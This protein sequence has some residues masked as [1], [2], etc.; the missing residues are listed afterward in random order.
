[1]SIITV[2]S[3]ADKGDG[4]LR[5]AIALA[6][7]EDNILFSSRLRGKTIKLKS[8]QL[9]LNKNLTID[10]SNAPE[11]VISGNN[12]SR[13][14]YLDREKRATIKNL[15]IADGK[16][17]G[18]GGGIDARHESVLLLDNVKVNNNKSELGGGIRV[19]HLAKATILNSS[20]Y[21]NDGTLSKKFADQSGGAITHSESR[22]QIFVKNTTFKKNKGFN[23]GAIFSF[24][25]VTLKVEDS[26]FIQ[27]S[28]LNRAG[29]G[30]IFTDGVS[31]R[32]YNSGFADDG[33]II[34]RTSRFE[35]NKAQGDGGALYLWGYRRDKAIL[36]DSIFINNTSTP[37]SNGKSKGGA[38]WVKMEL[39]MHNVT[40]ANNTA[41]Q[42]GGAVWLESLLPAKIVNSTFSGNRAVR[43]AG[44]A[45]FINSRTAPVNLTN[46]TIAY[47]KAGRA[48]GALWLASNHNVRLSNSIVAFNT[49]ER[50]RRQDQ[51]GYQ[52]RDGGG[53]LEYPLSPRAN[54]VFDNS[55][56]ANP[57]L[58][59]LKI[60]NGSLVHALK[61][62]SPAIN[63]GSN[64][65][66]PTADQRGALRDNQIDIGAFEVSNVST[67]VTIAPNPNNAAA[68][69]ETETNPV[70]AYFA[71]DESRGRRAKD[72]SDRYR[73]PATLSGGAT[74]APGKEQGG[75]IFNGEGAVKVSKNRA[76]DGKHD[77]R[78]VSLWFKPETTSPGKRQVLYEEGG[79]SRGLNIY[80]DADQLYVGGWNT[81]Q[82]ES[83]WTGTWLKADNI[84][85]DE[86][87]QVDLVLDGVSQLQDNALKGYL[88]GQLFD[89]GLGSQIWGHTDGIG[90]GN[91]NR[92]TRFHDGV[93]SSNKGFTGTIDEV[94]IANSV[95]GSDEL[96]TFL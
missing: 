63:A 84:L 6:K 87:H 43:D 52:P 93:T 60:V 49:A 10:G 32:N 82:K 25:G 89:S 20:F 80:L 71:F 68:L 8:G 58:A 13:V 36:R 19:G 85:V 30:A 91:T 72:S 22:G 77:Q 24:S 38:M 45:L 61:S 95:M 83:G 23:G 29:G 81:P 4:S 40:F 28:A 56:V 92:S 48:N 51:V 73:A 79:S 11:V 3:T 78:T 67:P 96:Q 15:T 55:I 34:I 2:T 16:T 64:A 54:R 88:D 33:K 47:N 42:Q 14:F 70:V 12:S 62:G 59:G 37:N 46:T 53:N 50:D 5:D 74:W 18:A 69:T 21:G 90:I 44:G 39:D 86:W 75:V 65:N 94:I 76:I 57:L 9:L 1:M 17:R 41:G 31:S 35:D 27:N 7:N 66:A 26:T